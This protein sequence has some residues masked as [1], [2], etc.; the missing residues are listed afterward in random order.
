MASEWVMYLSVLA[1]GVLTIAGVS[2]SFEVM[3]LRVTENTVEVGLSETTS[4][5]AKELKS[6]LELGMM[7]DP[8]TLV[9]IN[10]SFSLPSDLAGH[11]YEIHFKVLPNSN[12]W[13][14]EGEDT[15]DSKTE[16][17]EYETTIPWRNVTLY[18]DQGTGLPIIRSSSFQHYVKFIRASGT[19]SIRIYIGS[20]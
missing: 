19:S 15:T 5:I 8:L 14:I 10:R 17:V 13:F 1:L 16:I 11:Q 20:I 3:N 9:Q 18:N 12:H 4:F 7:N 6:V 2:L